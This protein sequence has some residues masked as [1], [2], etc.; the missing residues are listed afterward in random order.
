MEQYYPFDSR[1]PI[2]RNKIGAIAEGDTLRLKILLHKDAQ[3]YSAYLI[4]LQDEWF[5]PKE[6]AMFPCG[7]LGDYTFYECE[8]TLNQGLYWY[9]FRYTSANGEFYVSK[10]ENSLGIIIYEG[11]PTYWQQTVFSREYETPNWLKGGIIYQIFPDRF[12]KS[13]CKKNNIPQDRYICE[14]WNSVPEYRQNTGNSKFL[15]NDYYGGDLKGIEE[16]L[17]YLVELGITCIYLNPIFEAHSNHRYNTANYL[18]I[19][20]MLGNEEDLC[21]LIEKAKKK[22]INIILD[23]VFSHTGD[24]S[25]YFNKNQR[26]GNTG[27]FNDYYSPYRNWYNFNNYPNDYSCWWGVP[28]LPETNENDLSFSNFITGENGVLRYWLKKGIKGWRLDVADELPDE[29]LE[30]IRLSV[31]LEGKENYLLGEVWED[32]SNKISYGKRRKFL[33]GKQLDSVMN[34]PFAN[35]IVGFLKGDSSKK[36]INIVSDI[37]EN[38]PKQSVDLL[39]NHIGTHDT[40]RILTRLGSENSDSIPRS[41]QA[42]LTLSQEEYTKGIQLLKL[43]AVLQYTLPGIPSVYYGDEVG[44][45]GYGDPFCRAAYP[46]GKENTNLLDFYKKLG[47]VRKSNKP[48]AEGYFMP[49]DSDE[50]CIIY[51]RKWENEEIF[52]AVNPNNHPVNIKLPSIKNKPKI[53]FVKGEFKENITLDNLSFCIFK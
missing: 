31:K 6:C 17:D 19:D 41:Q 12:Y 20:S 3:V 40:A 11:K 13:N 27:A 29:F 8:I 1:N 36:L 22:K 53:L 5:K 25:I 50:D 18:K 39:M 24:D 34:Y 28:S 52:I 43:A 26:Y 30:K 14:D 9:C 42:N 10:T 15:G 4:L 32:A 44:M 33:Q 7:N 47:S 38:Y 37:C 23:G 16:K 35:A 2:Y 51:S 46:W 21:S 45:S 49:Y 48:F